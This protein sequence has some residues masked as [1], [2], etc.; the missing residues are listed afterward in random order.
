M[1]EADD[2][3]DTQLIRQ[4]QRGFHPLPA[5]VPGTVYQAAGHAF[6]RPGGIHLRQAFGAHIAGYDLGAGVQIKEGFHRRLPYRNRMQPQ[7]AEAAGRGSGAQI[8][9]Q[10][11][12][13]PFR[14]GGAETVM[15]EI[16]FVHFR[17]NVP[18]K[19]MR[20][21]FREAG[22]QAFHRAL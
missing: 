5:A 6:V 9:K 22:A 4:R 7:K 20:P 1:A 18:G 11:D 21:F 2:A 14:C 13:V 15:G 16:D 8:P 12:G 19:G 3:V 10:H 17:G